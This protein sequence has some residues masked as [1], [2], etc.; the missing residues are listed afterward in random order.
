MLLD[1]SRQTN[2]D[3]FPLKYETWNACGIE[4]LD[5]VIVTGGMIP[6]GNTEPLE[7]ISLDLVTVYNEEGWVENWPSLS[8]ARHSH[9]CGHFV[10]NKNQQVI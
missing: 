4:M 9:G 1:D 2:I 6:A 5:R 10:N 7:K 3:H 8:I